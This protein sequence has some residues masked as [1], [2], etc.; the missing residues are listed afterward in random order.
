M[1]I[2]TT[3]RGL[4]LGASAFAL[5]AQVPVGFALPRRAAKASAFIDASIAR[6]SVEEK[7][8]Q[9]TL[10]SSAQQTDTAAAANPINTVPTAEGQ[11]AAA[12]AGRVTGIFNGSNVLWHQQLQQAALQSRLQIPLLFAAD[13]IHGFTTVFPVPLAEAASFEPALAQRTARAA[14]LEAS[15]VG[16]DWTFAPMVDIARDARWGRGV[17]GSGEDVLLARRFAQARVRG[18]QGDGLD[19]ADALAACPKHFAAYGAAEAGLDYNTVDISERSLREIYFPPF[20]AA[21]DAGAVTTMA[22]FNEIAGIPATAN[23]WL[24]SD[25][26]RGEW[27]Y[28]GLVVS[29][30]TGDLELIGHGFASDAREATKLAFLAGV[31]ISMQSGL[32]LQHLP[33]LVAAGEVTMTQLDA[34]VRRVLQ[35]KAELGLFDNPFLRI[36]PARAQA[37]QRRPETL[38]LAREAARKSIVLLKNDG[39]LLPLKRQGQRIALIGPMARN[40]VDSAGPWT[41]FGG[42]DSG[43][44][45]ATALRAR[46]RDP[47]T[48]Q[49]VEGCDFEHGLPGGVQAAVTA[50]A[51]ADV[52]VLAIGEPMRYSGEAQS[53]SEIVIPSVQQSLLAAVAATGT[54]VVVVLS[55]GRAL[56]LD[57]PV[58]KAPA[59]L[60]SWFLGS[61]SG[62]ALTDI[63]FGE[64]GPSG[65]L[66]V[67]YPHASG[68]VPYSYAHKPSGRADPRPDALQPFKTRYRTAPNAALFPFGHGLTYGRIEYGEMI[69]SSAQMT[70][71]GNLRIS[72]RIH[73]RGTRDAEEVAQLYIRDRSASVTRPVRELKDFRKVA[74]PAG[75]SVAV[76]FVLRR[77]DLLFIGQALKPT[78]ESGVF[79][80]WV[81]PSAEAAGVSARFE[82]MG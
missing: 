76:E 72:A 3:R 61:Q 39:E 55:N 65:R 8:G 54:P 28:R 64:H 44:D 49:V 45:L 81:A 68:Q 48:L 53:R 60:V 19:H 47:N 16:I 42:D 25:V 26:L 58:L 6:M 57:G 38:A 34:S 46:L 77:E 12:R 22:A 78:V 2:R 73:N 5:L 21:F 52:A 27:N 43:N 51:S 23:R 15:A 40:W 1:G 56:V 30:Y 14:A 36:V 75:G 69:L 33:E 11:L 37:R 18:F 4:L 71:T 32:Y 79:D 82:L 50:A 10:S 35:F 7:A 63:L 66:P 70:A 13:V 62:A 80:V 20:Q 74:V 67:S 59:I 31:D 9:L 29:D 41:L 17:E 24:L